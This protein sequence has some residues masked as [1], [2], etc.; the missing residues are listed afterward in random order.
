MGD[1]NDDDIDLTECCPGWTLDITVGDV[2][3]NLHHHTFL[4][5]DTLDTLLTRLTGRATQADVARTQAF[6]AMFA[7]DQGN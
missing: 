3:I 4:A 7:T 5:P 2:N 6:A 1:N